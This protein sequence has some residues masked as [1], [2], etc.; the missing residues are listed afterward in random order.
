VTKSTQG[1]VELGE[2]AE[3]WPQSAFSYGDDLPAAR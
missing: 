1:I 3:Q 2:P